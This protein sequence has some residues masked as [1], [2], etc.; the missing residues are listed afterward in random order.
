MFL[1]ELL[2]SDKVNLRNGGTLLNGNHHHTA[3]NLDSDILEE[4][5]REERLDRLRRLLV[6]HGIANFYW[7]ITEHRPGFGSLDSVNPD[8]FDCKGVKCR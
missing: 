5:G 7:Q 6:R 8:I 1:V 3:V 2:E 4:A